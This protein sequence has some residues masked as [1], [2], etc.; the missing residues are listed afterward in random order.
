MIKEEI[1]YKASIKDEES[2]LWHKRYGHLNYRSLC[3]LKSKNI[4]IDELN[5]KIPEN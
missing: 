4:V 2:K 1:C 3:L 5:V